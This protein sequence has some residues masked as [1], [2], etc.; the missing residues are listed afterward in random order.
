MN[1]LLLNDDY[2]P[3]QSNSV[4]NIV[5]ALKEQY[6]KAGHTVSVI[7]THRPEDKPAP[8]CVS[9][10]VSYRKSLRSWRSLKNKTVS[11]VLSKHFAELKPDVVHAH[12]VHMWLTYESLRIASH[13]AKTYLTLHDCMSFS[14]GRLNLRKYLDNNNAHLSLIDH[15]KQAGLEVNPLRNSY[16][17]KTLNSYTAKCIP[18]STSLEEALHANGI[19]NTSVIH[20]GIAMHNAIDGSGFRKKYNLDGKQVVLFGGRMTED[21]GMR[22][23]HSAMKLVRQKIPNAVLLVVGDADKWKHYTGLAKEDEYM[24]TGWLAKDELQQAYAAA[25]VVSTPSVCL[26]TFNLM[27]V[28]AMAAGKPVVGTCFGGAPEIVEHNK[29]GYICDPRDTETFAMYL[30][31]LLEN[32]RKAEQMGEAGRKRVEKHFTVEQMANEY[33]KLFNESY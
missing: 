10:P 17:R 6:E 13:Y 33:L 27:N 20:N 31:D 14:Y 32:P 15:W 19:A 11:E 26:D 29:T 1:I 8:D 4:T 2:P 23:V 9:I 25:D 3:Y 28:E 7:T 21:K 12:N 18:V 24:C 30:I 5:V 16:I 22:E